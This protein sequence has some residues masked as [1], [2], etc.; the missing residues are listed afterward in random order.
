MV[1]NISDEAHKMA[2]K[3]AAEEKRKL[4]EIIEQA[5]KEYCDRAGKLL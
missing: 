4:Y 2:K 1:I 5:I 3:Q